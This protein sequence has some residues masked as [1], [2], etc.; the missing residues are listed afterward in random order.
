MYRVVVDGRVYDFSRKSDLS[1]R[2]FTINAIAMDVA[3]G[4]MRDPH[5]G[6]ED[7]RRRVVRMIAA[8]HFDDDPLRML[9]AVRLAVRST[10]RSMTPRSPQPSARREN[11]VRR[12]GAGDVRVARDVLRADFSRRSSFIDRS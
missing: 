10:S 5:G 12:G 6:Q 4:A 1:R 11:H 2:D 3:S 8:E 7:I 9:R